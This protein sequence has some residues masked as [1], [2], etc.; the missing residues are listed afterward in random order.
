MWGVCVCVSIYFIYIIYYNTVARG[1]EL[2]KKQQTSV[3]HQ[4]IQQYL[5]H[6][7][8]IHLTVYISFYIKLYKMY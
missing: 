5:L 3:V 4:Y 7:S 1:P 6:L 2:E 8:H